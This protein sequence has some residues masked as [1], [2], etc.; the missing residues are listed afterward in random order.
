MEIE[1]KNKETGELIGALS[2][3]AENLMNFFGFSY[4]ALQGVTATATPIVNQKVLY[5]NSDN[6]DY[7]SIPTQNFSAE[8]DFE[9]TTQ[10]AIEDSSYVPVFGHSSV[11][12]RI[13]LSGITDKIA[14]N[15]GGGALIQKDGL[16]GYDLTA[17][18]TTRVYRD[19]S[20]DVWIQIDGGTPV[21][22]TNNT[23]TF[24]LSRICRTASRE[25]KGYVHSFRIGTA[26]FD[27]SE[28]SGNTLTSVD[29]S[30]TATIETNSVDPN[31]INDYVWVT[32]IPSGGAINVYNEGVP[33]NN[34]F[35]LTQR[36]TDV[37]QHSPDLCIIMIGANDGL[38]TGQIQTPAQFNTNL[39]TIVAGLPGMDIILAYT[40]CCIDSYKKAQ[41]D[42]T[43]IYGDE[44]TYDL[45]DK[46]Q[47]L[48]DEM[49]DVASGHSNVT[50]VDTLAPFTANGDPQI[51][52]GSY[53]RNALNAG[54]QE[55]GVHPTNAGQDAI[56]TALEGACLGYTDIVCFGDSI[57]FG[58]GATGWPVYLAQKL[59]A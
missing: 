59:N 14:M 9:I 21:L 36:L 13:L 16:T 53:I 58:V 49:D 4:T 29:N 54:G 50:V 3:N 25:F 39:E 52:V 24:D 1:L 18:T 46:L 12:S 55:D 57:T 20:N 56:A 30:L 44:S 17:K 51:T 28:Q 42:Y 26:V 2:V 45:N 35:D 32:P 22:I 37:T 10:S 38:N 7:I 47:L 40:P 23:S 41:N 31:Y 6:V 5:L 11:G 43:P 48:R 15:I 34:S 8:F 19:S 33:N 27:L